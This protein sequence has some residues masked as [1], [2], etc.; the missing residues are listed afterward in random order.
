MAAFNQPPATPAATSPAPAPAAAVPPA[1]PQQPLSQP[2]NEQTLA[3]Q[4]AALNAQTPPAAAPATD[5]VIAA[6]Q[7][8]LPQLAPLL[9]ADDQGNTPLAG[10]I[11]LYGLFTDESRVDDLAEWWDSIGEEFGFF[12]DEPG[13]GAAAGAAAAQTPAAP[14]QPDLSQL[15]PA[16]AA[17]IQGLQ[18]QVQELSTGLQEQTTQQKVQA[19]TEKVRGDLSTA[20]QTAGVPNHDNIKSEEATDILRMALSYGEDPEAI[21]KATARYA[22]ITGARAPAAAEGADPQLGGV[23]ALQAALNGGVVPQQPSRAAAPA[24]ALGRGNADTEPEP[25]KSWEDARA[26]A[27]QRLREANAS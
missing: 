13:Q 1:A 18:A 14:G 3:H 16:V 17:V 9:E 26:L 21:Q 8:M 6:L 20:M 11:G 24:S 12:E 15:D 23:A 10:L 4:L 7:P 25:V 27:L 22:Q 19:Q 2:G 5:P